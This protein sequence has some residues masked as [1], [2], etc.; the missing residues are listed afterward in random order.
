MAVENV[1]A[2]AVRCRQSVQG[3]PV[4][5]D[6]SDRQRR[7]AFVLRRK[8]PGKVLPGAHAVDREYRVL[9]A[10]GAQGFPV[11]RVYALCEDESVIGTPFYVMDMVP[12]RIVWE[13]HFPDMSREDALPTSTR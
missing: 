6:L 5:P 1:E 8:P 11:P 4:Q 7:R 9:A 13:A 10:L 3:R 2:F 12:G